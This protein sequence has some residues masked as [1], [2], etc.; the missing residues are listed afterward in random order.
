MLPLPLSKTRVQSLGQEDLLEKEMATHSSI[1]A[2]KIPWMEESG[3]LQSIGS[4]K[5]RHDSAT[6]L[7]HSLTLEWHMYLFEGLTYEIFETYDKSDTKYSILCNY[8]IITMELM[9]YRQK[10]TLFLHHLKVFRALIYKKK[11]ISVVWSAQHSHF[12]LV[13]VH[14]LLI[15][16]VPCVM[17]MMV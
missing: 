14:F 2:L 4:Q 3:R 5:V 8:F 6:S 15:V 10:S 11:I 9:I 13:L 7:T 1:L 17:Q 16:N 12:L